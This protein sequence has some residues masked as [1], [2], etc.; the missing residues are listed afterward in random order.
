[1]KGPP[2]ELTRRER[3][4]YY[5]CDLLLEKRWKL[6]L[7]RND[8]GNYRRQ[9]RRIKQGLILHDWLSFVRKERR[10]QS[11]ERHALGMTMTNNQAEAEA[12][13]E[14]AKAKLELSG[15]KR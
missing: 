4:D 13:A 10:K 12:K 2:Q 1:V 8:I 3:C 11:R 6:P 5:E 15:R 14:A 9:E 7:Q